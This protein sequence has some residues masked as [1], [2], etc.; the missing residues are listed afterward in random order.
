[1]RK[2]YTTTFK[3]HIVKSVSFRKHK[4]SITI[5]AK[6]A[7]TELTLLGDLRPSQVSFVLLKTSK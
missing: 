7:T 4:K 2:W 6:N 3:Q 1:V 5:F